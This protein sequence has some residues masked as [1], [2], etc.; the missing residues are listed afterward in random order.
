MTVNPVHPV[1]PIYSALTKA[2]DG[3]YP[4]I[5]GGLTFTP[6]LAAPDGSSTLE[7][8][9][10]FTGHAFLATSVDPAILVAAGADGYGMASSPAVLALLGGTSKRAVF[11]VTDATMFAR[12][13]AG[14]SA[15]ST[16]TLRTDLEDHHRVR[17]ARTVRHNVVVYADERGLVTLGRGLAGRLEMSV[18]AAPQGQGRGW[19]RSLINEAL[20]LVPDD[21]LVFAAVA[22]GNARSIRAFLG[23][24]FTII[25]SETIIVRPAPDHPDH[26]DHSDHPQAR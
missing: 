17:H 7:V 24:G 19:G 6:A 20:R 10:A 4:P 25:G 12:G 23:L 21:D 9:V 2:V 26:F 3:D 1:H 13:R 16:L 18:E 14:D 8:V 5:D 11:G 15:A 22:P